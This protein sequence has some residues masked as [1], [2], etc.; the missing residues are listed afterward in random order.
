M[1]STRQEFWNQQSYAVIGDTR[2]GRAFP[3]LTFNGLAK[4]GKTVYAVDPATAD[5]NDASGEKLS[6]DL[7][8]A[9]IYPD[10]A[11]LPGDVDG[12]VLEVAKAETAGWVGRVADAGI[13]NL[14]IH[15]QTDTPEALAMAKERGLR[16]EHGTCAVMYVRPGFS[17][18][19]IHRAIMKLTKKF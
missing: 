15:Q 9:T 6:A 7:D 17:P 19:A 10:L 11:A 12:A 13:T 4:L 8:G 3:K 1:S 18:H 2:G 16:T 5:D 14:W